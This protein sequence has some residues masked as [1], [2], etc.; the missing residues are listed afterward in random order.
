MPG[1]ARAGRGAGSARLGCAEIHKRAGA[2]PARAAAPRPHGRARPTGARTGHRR[3]G[4]AHPRA[5]APLRRARTRRTRSPMPLPRARMSRPPT[6]ESRAPSWG[7]RPPGRT[8][9]RRGQGRRSCART[10][11]MSVRTFRVD[12]PARPTPTRTLRPESIRCDLPRD[13]ALYASRE[14]VRGPSRSMALAVAERRCWGAGQR[15][16]NQRGWWDVWSCCLTAGSLEGGGQWARRSVVAKRKEAGA[17]SAFIITKAKRLRGGG[18]PG[19]APSPSP[20]VCPHA[21]GALW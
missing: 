16:S 11:R 12:A 18:L 6:N 4:T 3:I 21:R 19:G 1:G 17:R 20:G 14:G 10:A 9:R 5:R 13:A 7:S 2:R 15:W 8:H